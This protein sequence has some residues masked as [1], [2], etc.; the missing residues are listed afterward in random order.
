MS[1][2]SRLRLPRISP[3]DLAII[4]L[5]A[6]FAVIGL[7]IDTARAEPSHIK[8][9]AG[10][11]SGK[12]ATLDIPKASSR[13]PLMIETRR[14]GVAGSR[15]AISIDDR[16][17]PA[18]ATVLNARQCRFDDDGS[19]CLIRIGQ[20]SPAYRRLVAALEKGRTAHVQIINAGSMQMS[21]DVDL[22][23]F[24]RSLRSAAR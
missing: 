16:K 1:P 5:L 13:A 4:L 19:R 10:D 6:A 20:G 17:R 14:V 12:H 9:T 22:A 18:F 7:L 23:G 24:R 3:A 15:L 8:L 21:E 11:A 2:T